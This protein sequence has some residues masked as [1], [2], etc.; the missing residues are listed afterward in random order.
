MARRKNKQVKQ[1]EETLVDVV[2]RAETVQDYVEQ[3]SSKIMTIIGV[4]VLLVAA[5]VAYF[6]FYKAPRDKEAAEL[7]QYA[8]FNFD[9][10]QYAIA[11]DGDTINPDQGFLDII[12]NYSGTKSANLA[13]YYAGI[14][15]LNLGNYD[16]AVEYLNDYSEKGRVVGSYKYAAL[17]D[18]YSELEQMDKALSNYRKAAS[19]D[20][21]EFSTPLHLMKLAFFL[22]NQGQAD[23]AKKT[24]NMITSK[25]P[26]SAQA[27]DAK[28]YLARIGG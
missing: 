15:Y 26:S 23:E 16:V 11:L 5:V 4:I 22:E 10:E 17:G 6:N 21:N 3:N 12:D 1:E 14:S 27:V 7:I 8:Q 28:K 19:T 25:Y 9:N 20:P 13:H 18:A 24:Y 2:G